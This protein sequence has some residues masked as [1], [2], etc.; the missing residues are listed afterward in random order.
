MAVNECKVVCEADLRSDLMTS[1]TSIDLTNVVDRTCNNLMFLTDDAGKED[2]SDPQS[3]GWLS[4]TTPRSRIVTSLSEVKL[5]YSPTSEVYKAAE[6]FFLNS[7]NRGVTGFFF[8]GFW[9]RENAEGLA[10]ALDMIIACQPCWTHL[11]VTH[12]L[13]S[14]TILLDDITMLEIA[15]WAQI[16]DRIPYFLSRDIKNENPSDATTLKAQLKSLGLV[17]SAVFYTRGHCRIVTDPVTGLPIYFAPGET[18]LDENGDPV[19]DPDNPGNN[20]ISDGTEPRL[21]VHYPYLEMLSAGWA[22]NVDFSQT[23][24]DYT[25][26]YKPLGGQGWIGV[27]VDRLTNADVTAITGVFPDGTVNPNNNGYAN[28][29][30]QTAGYKV[31]FPGITVGGSWI[32]QLHLNLFLKKRLQDAIAQLMVGSRRVPYDD[33]RG[34]ILIGNAVALVMSEAQ[35]NG[36]FTNDPQPWEKFGSYV[37]KGDGWVI[38]QDNF[39]DQTAARKNQ[40]IAPALS[41]CY[42]PAGAVHHVPITICTLAVPTAV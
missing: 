25:L 29:Y 26:A 27:K 20:L 32:N 24:S 10:T 40:R 14:G 34:K 22:A 11:V 15:E 41:V 38:R 31:T 7:G 35:S 30:V 2:V 6:G 23:G 39:A 21:E 16:N 18:V 9:D 8:V 33:A 28:V 5:H 3:A 1:I 13:T 19:D 17:N 42:I 12:Y 4:A 36:H 37:R